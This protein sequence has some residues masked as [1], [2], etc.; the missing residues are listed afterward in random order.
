MHISFRW[1]DHKN[2]VGECRGSEFWIRGTLLL[3]PTIYKVFRCICNNLCV[4]KV[5]KFCFSFKFKIGKDYMDIKICWFS[6]NV[7]ERYQRH[8]YSNIELLGLWSW[9]PMDWL[10]NE[11][12][13]PITSICIVLYYYILLF[14]VSFY[15]NKYC[16][17]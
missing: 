7:E 3:H 4:K 9:S 8:P 15:V 12:Y 11:R 6:L 10:T 16:L 13:S 5:I 14:S 2:Y 17:W 1:L